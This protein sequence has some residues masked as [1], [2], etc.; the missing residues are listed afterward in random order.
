MNI[1]RTLFLA[2]GCI[3][4]AIGC[5]GIIVP[6]LPSFPFFVVTVYCFARSSQRMHDWFVGT[7]MYKNHLE[8]FVN[9]KGM[10]VQTKI[11]V[12]VMVTLLLG[13]G[14]AMMRNVPIGRLILAIV[15]IGH[16]FY[17]IFGVKTYE[18]PVAAAKD[19]S[20]QS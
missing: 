11:R 13:F 19:A 4:L 5:I 7:K 3:S 6:F 14:F 1:K 12:I 20:V 10:T 8:P 15:W 9:K 17:F 2:I 16:V 18:K